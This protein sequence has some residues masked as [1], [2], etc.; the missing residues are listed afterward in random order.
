MTKFTF[1]FLIVVLSG[2]TLLFYSKARSSE[3]REA[4]YKSIAESAVN[5]ATTSAAPSIGE[6]AHEHFACGM[7]LGYAAAKKGATA[8]DI[9]SL[10]EMQRKNDSAAF[11][12]WY[13]ARP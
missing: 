9:L 3:R 5:A 1:A 11:D 4:Q 2:Q 12:K 13:A 6:I 7:K 10:I 8:A